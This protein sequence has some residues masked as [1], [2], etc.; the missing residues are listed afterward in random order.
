MFKQRV[1]LV[2]WNYKLD[3]V[4]YLWLVLLRNTY[5]AGAHNIDDVNLSKDTS[6]THLLNNEGINND[7]EDINIIKHSS[8]HTIADIENFK[9]A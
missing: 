3:L 1:K 2:N 8:Y 4:D 9:L 5:I 6:L 7:D